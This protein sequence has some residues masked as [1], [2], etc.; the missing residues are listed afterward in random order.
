MTNLSFF[1]A[2]SA[3]MYP[4]SIA[5][6]SNEVRS[7]DIT[8]TYAKLHVRLRQLSGYLAEIG[9]HPG[10]RVAVMLP[11]SLVF[12]LAYYGIMHA[13]AI[14]VP[15]SPL[16]SAGGVEFVLTTTAARALLAAPL[17]AASVAGAEAAGVRCI[18]F[19]DA[20]AVGLIERCTPR[21]HAVSRS[22]D[23]TA[24]VLHTSGTT[25]VLQAVELTHGNLL[26][27]QAIVAS[28][29]LGLGPH[30]I[31]MDC[32]PLFDAF[33][34]TYGL[35]AT[36]SSG[37]TLVLLPRFTPGDAL[38]TLVAAKVT[39]FHGVPEMYAAIL[40]VAAESA[41][42]VNT[43]SLRVCTSRGEALPVDVLRRFESRF[44]CTVLESHGLSED[45]SGVVS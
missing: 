17:T 4:D 1:V 37:A 7:D 20:T 41:N 32:L 43:E 14:V 27:N 19:D 13:G 15:M 31:V 44:G 10:D 34:M 16:Q 5:L 22:D 40:S 26:R 45:F 30:D 23:D 35:N 28:Q 3:D 38:E 18:A 29:V 11:N 8:M 36:M 12:A 2:E 9:I 39:V 25:G 33:G 6:R 42:E 24:V 21:D